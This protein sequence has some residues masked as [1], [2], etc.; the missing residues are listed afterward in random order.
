[1]TIKV[2]L[3]LSRLRRVLRGT[4]AAIDR[5]AKAYAEAVKELASQLAPYDAESDEDHLRDSGEV[6]PG[7]REGTYRVEFGRNLPDKRA[8]YQEFG[9]STM[10]AQPYLTPALRNIDPLPF[11]ARE[12]AE[13]SK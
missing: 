9:T 4:P 5:G 3:N 10:S 7:E 1:M 8:I 11:F 2:D 13:L 6:L 12:F